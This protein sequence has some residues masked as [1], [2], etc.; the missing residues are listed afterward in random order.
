MLSGVQPTVSAKPIFGHPRGLLF[1]A[2]TELWDRISFHGMQALLVL[3]MVEQLLL[4]GH[5]EHVVGLTQLRAAIQ[6]VTGPLSVQ[7]LAFQIFGLYVGLVY[8][9]PVFG[10]ALGDRVLG[11][12]RTVSLGALLMT[13]GHFCL[14]F[15][16][17]FLLALLFLITGAGCFRGNLQPQ[18]GELYAKDDR[19]RTTA[20]QV[21]AAMINLGA[22]IAPIVTGQLGKSFSWHVGFAFAGFGMLAGLVIYL[23]GRRYLPPDPPRRERL[24]APPL[25]PDERRVVWYLIA[26]LPIATLFWIAQSQ[27]WNTY[28]IWVRDHL[29]ITF[30][31]WTMPVPWLQSLDGLAPFICLPP[32]V[33]LWRWQAKRGREP[34]EFTKMAIGC[35]IF[36]A[37]TLLLA[38]ASMMAGAHGRASLLWAIAFHFASNIG[39]IFFAPTTTA[40]VSRAAPDKINA[41]MIGGYSLAVFAGSVVSGRLGSL[42]ERWPASEFWLL[43]AALVSLGGVLVLGFGALM[44]PALRQVE[45]LS[46]PAGAP[47]T[48]MLLEEG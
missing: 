18:A 17:S 38:A 8:F 22:F 4:P 12:V 27:I 47:L 1:I 13:A 28:N 33:M 37:S 23:S 25:T 34:N 9:T 42:Y 30:G 43:H 45:P 24:A 32:M 44:K 26:M 20:F 2:G 10:G 15:D 14:A 41:T 6:S 7:A 21:Y 5:A 46:V 48:Q 16:Q 40:L 3:Y 39:W 29:N 35:W 31:D 19:R 36:G 11:R